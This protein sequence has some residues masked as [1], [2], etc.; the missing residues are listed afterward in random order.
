MIQP[1]VLEPFSFLWLFGIIASIVF[2]FFI[3]QLGIRISKD[4]KRILMIIMGLIMI[5]VEV[6]QQFYLLRLDLWTVNTS[7]PIHL[8]GISG[9]LAGVIM[10]R[11][12]Q[13]IFEFLALIGT[14]GALHALLTPQFNHGPLSFL[15]Y[16]Y[17]ISHAGIILI[18]LFLTIINGYRLRKLA[19]FKVA[20]MCQL[21][22]IIIG[23]TNY[24]LGSN[25]MYL[26][27]RPLVNNPMIVGD[28]PWYII[29]F[30]ILGLIHILIFFFG[31]QKIR[32]LQKY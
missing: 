13:N 16:K 32:P 20:L 7:L 15:V 4:N 24:F 5:L 17:Y 19:W 26:A 23:I 11:P 1:V 31:Y 9:I 22:I 6:M 25:Y 12:N 30:Q 3:L 29:G 8:C 28:W 14:P 21:L 10:L 2:S 18:P 27:Q